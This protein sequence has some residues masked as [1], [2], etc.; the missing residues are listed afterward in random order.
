MQYSK[1]GLGVLYFLNK[2]F[3]FET[4]LFVGRDRKIL[5]ATVRF[6]TS[7]TDRNKPTSGTFAVLF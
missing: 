6:G 4:E 7:T 3:N 1:I 2:L 5:K